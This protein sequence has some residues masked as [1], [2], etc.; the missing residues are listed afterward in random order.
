MTEKPRNSSVASF[1]TEDNEMF[2]GVSI[3]GWDQS[4][5]VLLR[6]PASVVS[7]LLSVKAF[8]T[9]VPSR[10]EINPLIVREARNM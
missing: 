1:S 4:E 10:S 2:G 7:R 5:Y 3:V 8:F 9:H 6:T